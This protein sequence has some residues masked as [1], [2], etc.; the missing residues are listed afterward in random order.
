MNPRPEL[1]DE[2]VIGD[3]ALERL[4]NLNRR[5]ERKAVEVHRVAQ[6]VMAG[7]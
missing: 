1:M 6:G 4:G 5:P 3:L 2:L 7:I